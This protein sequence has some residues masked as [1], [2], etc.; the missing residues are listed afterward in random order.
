LGCAATKRGFAETINVVNDRDHDHD[1][2]VDE[3]ED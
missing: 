3:H 1:E 2:D